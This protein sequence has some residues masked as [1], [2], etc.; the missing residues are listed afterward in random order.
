MSGSNG[1]PSCAGPRKRVLRR[2]R[3]PSQPKRSSNILLNT[4]N[5]K[6]FQRYGERIELAGM[7]QR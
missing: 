3:R 4:F 7:G 5:A 1:E 2:R 6:D